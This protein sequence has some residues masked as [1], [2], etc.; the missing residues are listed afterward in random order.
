[1]IIN[2]ILKDYASLLCLY[3]S[4]VKELDNSD[5][6]ESFK[7]D[8]LQANWELIVERQL[9]DS[10]LYL[11]VYGDGADCNGVSSR[12]L[13]PNKQATHNVIL[14]SENE[15]K[16]YDFLGERYIDDS[17]EEIVFQRFVTIKDDGWY[18]EEPPFDMI[19]ALYRDEVVI[20]KFSAVN[21]ELNII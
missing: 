21:A 5:T 8:W 9:G 6:T 20:V 1:M 10:D 14:K 15:E 16:I 11:E 3:W 18:Y 4:K 2:N 17:I 19:E 12:V 13:F 7:D